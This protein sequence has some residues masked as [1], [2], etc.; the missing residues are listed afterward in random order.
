MPLF[1]MDV[2]RID[3]ANVEIDFH[4]YFAK[5][6]ISIVE[7]SDLIQSELPKERLEIIFKIIDENKRVLIMKPY[8]KKYE[9]LCEAV[10]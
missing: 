1:H 5:K 6:G 7:W 2:Y 8:G 9:D 4:E 10:L 3:E